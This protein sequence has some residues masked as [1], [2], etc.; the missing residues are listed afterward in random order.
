M[1]ARPISRTRMIQSGSL[2]VPTNHAYC[3]FTLWTHGRGRD[4]KEAGYR[5]PQSGSTRHTGRTSTPCPIIW[6]PDVNISTNQR[7]AVQCALGWHRGRW[8]VA[9]HCAAKL[10]PVVVPTHPSKLLPISS[11]LH[12]TYDNIRVVIF[13]GRLPVDCWESL[14]R[15]RVQMRMRN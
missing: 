10:V 6:T 8:W 11:L 3:V 4:C 15:R 2:W 13:V 9:L 5:G 7:G 14:W 1:F 12:E